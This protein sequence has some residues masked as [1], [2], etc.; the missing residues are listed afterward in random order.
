MQTEELFAAYLRSVSSQ[1]IF[2]AYLLS[3]HAIPADDWSKL[4][5][6]EEDE[7]ASALFFYW[8]RRPVESKM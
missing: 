7:W 6:M 8:V 2:A 1:R 3:V 5:R 4:L